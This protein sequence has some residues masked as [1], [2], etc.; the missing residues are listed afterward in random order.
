LAAFVD[1]RPIIFEVKSIS[2]SN[3]RSQVRAGLSQ[4]YEYRYVQAAQDAALVLATSSP[5]PPSER[6]MADYLH[7]D[8]RILHI[9]DGNG[10]LYATPVVR[11][12]LAFLW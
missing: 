11:K 8:R 3:A 4:L 1:G 5:L 2:L 6:W 9:W 10:R 7:T 12:E